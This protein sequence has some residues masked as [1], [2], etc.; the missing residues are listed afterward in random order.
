M[1]CPCHVVL[2]A[3]VCASCCRG[4]FLFTVPMDVVPCCVLVDRSLFFAPSHLVPTAHHLLSTSHVKFWHPCGPCIARSATVYCP[5]RPVFNKKPGIVEPGARQLREPST[6]LQSW[7]NHDTFRT[8]GFA[9]PDGRPSSPSCA[10]EPPRPILKRVHI[11]RLIEAMFEFPS[12]RDLFPT[13][14]PSCHPI[15]D[16]PSCPL[17]CT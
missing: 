11:C 4:P 13:P 17:S 1:T 15:S 16:R 9:S 14:F 5:G 3:C 6:R 2:S 10:I 12:R 7:S 8:F